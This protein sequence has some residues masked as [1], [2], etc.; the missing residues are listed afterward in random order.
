MARTWTRWLPAGLSVLVVAGAAISTAP[1][2]ADD[3][4]HRTPQEVLS[5][6]AGHDSQGL[7]GQ[8]EQTSNLALPAL[9]DD[10]PG[11]SANTAAALSAFDLISSD[12]SGR[13]FLGEEDQARVQLFGDF[14]ERDLI[15]D[16]SQAWLYDSADDVVAHVSGGTDSRAPSPSL[17]P[18][19]MA[20][21]AIAAVEPSTRLSVREN[22]VVAGRTAYELVLDP[23]TDGTL[24]DEVSIAVD[25]ETGIPLRVAVTPHEAQGPAIEVA[26]TD[27]EL[28]TPD[29]GRF[30]FSPPPGA[31]VQQIE[32][33]QQHA[34]Q[35]RAG[36]GHEEYVSGTGWET[37]LSTAPGAV[38]LSDKPLLKQLTTSV[39]GGHVLR[40]DLLCALITDDG[41]LLLGAVPVEAL[42]AS[43]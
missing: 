5:L 35:P 9:P 7:V 13:V 24:V 19:E 12:H 32:P 28:K 38:D 8:F 27:L 26:Y 40:T 3:L 18:E 15:T 4:Q 22:V 20:D 25:G 41:R 10:L 23:R 1:A 33:P 39:D 34:P 21:R 6:L 43:A 30:T 42:Q 16:G 37:I 14:G 29:P 17:A 36:A 2:E 11:T 31:T